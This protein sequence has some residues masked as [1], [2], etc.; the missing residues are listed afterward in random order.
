MH[1][2]G[3]ADRFYV[4]KYY[5]M[6][7]FR[8]ETGSTIYMYLTRRR[9]MAAREYMEAGMSA[10]EACYRCGFHS[11]SSFT[12]SYGKHFGTTPTGRTDSNLIREEGFE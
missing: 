10:T 2:D 8:K 6:R 7:S 4:S 11:Y 5:M 12:R 1:I 3:L 9:L